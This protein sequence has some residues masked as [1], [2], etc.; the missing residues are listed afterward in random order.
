MIDLSIIIPVFN[1]EGY[2][3]ECLNSVLQIDDVNTQVIC[4][5]DMSTDDS[6]KILFSYKNR[7]NVE[8]YLNE[9]NSGLAYARNKGLTYIKGKYVMFVDSDDRVNA[10][11]IGDFVN[12]MKEERLDILYFDVEEFNDGD[13]TGGVADKRKRKK[14]YAVAAGAEIFD[15]MVRNDEMFG[16]VCGGIFNASFLSDYG[17]GF[18]NGTL[19]EDIPFTFRALLN[20]ERVN[21]VNRTGYFYRQRNDSI[22]HQHNYARRAQGLLL[23]YSQ[24]LIDWKTVSEKKCIDFAESSIVKYIDSVVSMME[25]NLTKSRMSIRFGDPIIN[26]FLSNFQ[27]NKY[28]KFEREIAVDLM[29]ALEGVDALAIYGAGKI[30][31]EVVGFLKSKGVNISIIFVSSIKGNKESVGDIPVVEYNAAKGNAY[32]AILLGV[33]MNTQCT[34]ADYLTETGYAGKIIREPFL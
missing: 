10:E 34:I 26:D 2:L 12:Q 17:L 19:H 30:A 25:S 18:I 4:V 33:S 22:L 15:K 3:E 21:V 23:D 24:M 20:A 29:K 9:K 7:E 14:Q 31:E 16:C 11:V 8:I 28:R 13:I 5:E 27:I 32:D 1:V 6:R